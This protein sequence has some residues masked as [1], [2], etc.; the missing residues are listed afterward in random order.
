MVGRSDHD[1]IDVLLAIEHLAKIR[2]TCGFRE[3]FGLQLDHPIDARLGFDGIERHLRL[4]RRRRGR[5]LDALLQPLDFNFEPVESSIGIAPVHVAKRDDVLACEVDQISATHA[6]DS[7]GGDVQRIA[8][9]SESTTEDVPRNNGTRGTTGG[10]V[11]QELAPGDFFLFAH[12][13]LSR[14]GLLRVGEGDVGAES[15]HA[16][17]GS[18]ALATA[19]ARAALEL[20][21][22]RSG[23]D[24]HKKI[25]GGIE[26]HGESAENDEL[27]E[28][29]TPLGRNELR[30]ER[31]EKERGLWVE[32]FSENPLTKGALRRLR[33]ADGHLR[34]SRADHADAEPN[35]IRGTRVLDGVKCQGGSSKDRGDSE[36]GGQDME[37]SANKGAERRKDTLTAASGE[38]ARQNVKDSRPW[39][40][41]QQ[42]GSGKEK[43]E[44]VR[45]EHPRIVWA[46]LPACKMAYGL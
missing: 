26:R 19:E 14:A 21:F 24:N 39:G 38:A 44:T 12:E 4:A 18:D 27:K 6:A 17:A 1:G 45:V 15:D 13:H 40:D 25:G 7:N 2:V 41:G 36:R 35:E 16:E 9:R 8:R 31:Q 10:D 5:Q 42:Q 30:E 22:E 46:R 33:W 29:V 20:A 34:I 37:E 11:G 3:A 32:N 28:N 43:Q 23:K